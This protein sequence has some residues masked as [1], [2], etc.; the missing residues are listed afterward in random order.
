MNVQ[1][2]EDT[3]L[4]IELER[5]SPTSSSSSV[6]KEQ[7][8]TVSIPQDDVKETGKAF[9]SNQEGYLL[10]R[11]TCPCNCAEKAP[12]LLSCLTL[13]AE[14][15]PPTPRAVASVCKTR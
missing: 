9:F 12:E 5:V 13:A 11:C 2:V 3:D 15:T 6:A 1:H 10:T 4:E 7:K 14:E 8:N